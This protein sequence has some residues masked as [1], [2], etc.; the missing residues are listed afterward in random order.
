LTQYTPISE[1]KKNLLAE[2]IPNRCVNKEDYETIMGWLEEFGI[3]EG[4]YQE[5]IPGSEWLPDFTQENP[6]P[7]KILVPVWHHNT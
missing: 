3:E 7:S 4:F 2:C 1:R 5:V 6:F